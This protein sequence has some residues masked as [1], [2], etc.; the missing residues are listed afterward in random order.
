MRTLATL[1]TAALLWGTATFASGYADVITLAYEQAGYTDVSVQKS[2]GD[3]LVTA[4]FNGQ[5]MTFVVDPSN[6]QSHHSDGMLHDV[7][8]DHGQDGPG[9]DLNDDHGQDGPGHDVGDDHGQ[10]GAGHDAGDDHGGDDHG[11]N[12][13][14]HD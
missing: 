11:R 2:R 9:H 8:D 12:G 14:G 1:T 6:G 4:S 5:S 10:Q 3:W 13:G 7:N